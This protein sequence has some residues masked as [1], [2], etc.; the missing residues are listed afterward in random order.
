MC[1]RDSK[2]VIGLKDL[3][4]MMVGLGYEGT[5]ELVAFPPE[6]KAIDIG[7]YYSDFSLIQKELGW[8]P[9]VSLREGLQKTI[10]YYKANSKHYW[11]TD[12]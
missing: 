12:Q 1:I 6:R 5:Y 11:E 4:E 7:D 10:D 3:A 2:E 8:S 9:M